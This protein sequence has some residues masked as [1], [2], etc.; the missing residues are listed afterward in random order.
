MLNELWRWPT[1]HASSQAT[2][3]TSLLRPGCSRR[4]SDF[5]L[6]SKASSDWIFTADP[7][8]TGII[9][10]SVQM[11]FAYAPAFSRRRLR[12]PASSPFSWRVKLVRPCPRRAQLATD[13]FTSAHREHHRC[14]DHR[15]LVRC[16]NPCVESS[17]IP[18]THR[19]QFGSLRYR[20]VYRMRDRH[21]LRRISEVLRR[22]HHL[23]VYVAAILDLND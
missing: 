14:V 23:C 21:V 8:L 13:A 6:R 20:H 7:A 12:S 1:T 5:L 19:S 10:G 9:G 11:F 15:R 4:A 18:Y 2:R 16:D 17:I 22:G 3:T